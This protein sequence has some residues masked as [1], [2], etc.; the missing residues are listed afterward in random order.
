MVKDIFAGTST[1]PRS[2]GNYV[3]PEQ[4]PDPAQAA[5][6]Q[7]RH[8]ATRAVE[9]KILDDLASKKRQAD[10]MLHMQQNRPV[11]TTQAQT[12]PTHTH[13]NKSRVNQ[14]GGGNGGGFPPSGGGTGEGT[15]IPPLQTIFKAA[16]KQFAPDLRLDSRIFQYGTPYEMAEKLQ[17]QINKLLSV[18]VK[19]DF[20]APHRDFLPLA[21]TNKLEGKS[22]FIRGKILEIEVALYVGPQLTEFDEWLKGNGPA[23]QVDVATKDVLIEVTVQ[24]TGKAGQIDKHITYDTAQRSVILYAPHYTPKAEESI[25]AL[26]AHVVRNR[27]ELA[28]VMQK[29]TKG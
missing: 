14:S 8:S 2:S 28:D 3:V 19:H 24:E 10:D 6:E 12:A 18:Q 5:A 17:E 11:E 1:T 23:R 25:T 4:R 20:T 26:G 22:D 27:H 21:E 13:D 9:Q 15:P 7:Q 29:L 16:N